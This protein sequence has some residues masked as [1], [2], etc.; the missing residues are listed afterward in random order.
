MAKKDL[1]EVK[2][3][4][5]IAQVSYTYQKNA[6]PNLTEDSFREKIIRLVKALCTH[7]DDKFYIIFH[8]KDIDQNGELKS[9][10]AHIYFEFKNSRFYSSL[11]K[12]LEI[13][14]NKNLQVVKDKA[15]V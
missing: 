10:H 2:A 12:T 13:S 3:R 7:D 11:F 15:K 6:D 14:R 5:Y 8:D 4:R 9:L 1:S